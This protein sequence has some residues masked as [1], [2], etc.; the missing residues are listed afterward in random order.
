M[1]HYLKTAFVAIILVLGLTFVIPT[2]GV[3]ALENTQ[4]SCGTYGSGSYSNGNT[5]SNNDNITAPNT[6]FA[7]QLLQPNNLIPLIASV[8]A[9]AFGAALL[10]KKHK[11]A[12]T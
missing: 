11:K 3:L 4:Y 12:K 1:R 6:G 9:I 2:T 8:L 7:D 10:F 5:C